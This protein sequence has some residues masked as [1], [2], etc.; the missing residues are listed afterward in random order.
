MGADFDAG[1]D[2]FIDTGALMARLDLVVTCDTSIAHLAGALGRPV[3][4]LLQRVSDWR[5]GLEGDLCPWYPSMR[6]IR[7]SRPG[8]W[9]E[10][11]SRLCEALQRLSRAW[12][13][14]SC[15]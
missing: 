1:P 8:D 6:L 5:F 12:P 15:N 10:P 3:F 7:Q 13:P 14:P 11:M 2:G 4:V 9:E